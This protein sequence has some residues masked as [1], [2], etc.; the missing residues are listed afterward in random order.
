MIHKPEFRFTP[1]QVI[2]W[3]RKNHHCDMC[4]GQVLAL[5]ALMVD[6]GWN[7]T[8]LAHH[9]HVGRATISEILSLDTFGSTETFNTLAETFGLKLIGFYLFAHFCYAA[10]ASP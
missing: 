2:L 6:R 9:S 3:C 7:M 4:A 1:R 8:Q 10:E 5:M